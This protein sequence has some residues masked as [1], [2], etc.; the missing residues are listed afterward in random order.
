M[1]DANLISSSQS[2]ING[3]AGS[4]FEISVVTFVSIVTFSYLS[5][6]PF[7]RLLTRVSIG[8]VAKET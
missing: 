4:K 7:F 2:N 1:H 8:M 6:I 5:Y 3:I